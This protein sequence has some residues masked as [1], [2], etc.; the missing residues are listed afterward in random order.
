MIKSQ[1]ISQSVQRELE[2][3][4]ERTIESQVKTDNALIQTISVVLIFGLVVITLMVL[5]VGNVNESY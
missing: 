5:G 2:A 1:I 4:N 3:I